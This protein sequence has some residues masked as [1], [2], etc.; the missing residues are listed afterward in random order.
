MFGKTVL[1][2]KQKRKMFNRL[3]EEQAQCSTFEEQ[4]EFGKKNGKQLYALG[5]VFGEEPKLLKR[6][7]RLLSD[8][9]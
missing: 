5:N 4:V 1:T 2:Q 6:D 7:A 3:I 9:V 8:L